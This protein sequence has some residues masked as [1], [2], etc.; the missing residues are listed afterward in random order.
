MQWCQAVAVS[1]GYAEKS[2]MVYKPFEVERER[3]VIVR[4]IMQSTSSS[5]SANE[6]TG[7]AVQYRKGKQPSLLDDQGLK[8]DRYRTIT[9]PTDADSLTIEAKRLNIGGKSTINMDTEQM[10]MYV[11]RDEV[12]ALLAC[13]YWFEQRQQQQNVQLLLYHPADISISLKYQHAGEEIRFVSP[14]QLQNV[15]ECINDRQINIQDVQDK[16]R[17]L[18]PTMTPKRSVNALSTS[19]D[20]G[21]AARNLD[22]ST[23]DDFTKDTGTIGFLNILSDHVLFEH[24]REPLDAEL[25]SSNQ[26]HDAVAIGRFNASGNISPIPLLDDVNLDG[27]YSGNNTTVTHTFN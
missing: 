19:H 21:D 4:V 26:A 8:V 6:V 20:L 27:C 10:Y 13:R 5:S 2:P 3:C 15:R 7:A 24:H 1:S 16:L 23:G 12:N 18:Q 9:I 14:D 11:F 25:L 22:R 17:H